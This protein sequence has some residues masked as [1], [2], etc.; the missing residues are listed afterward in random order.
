[1]VV[2]RA[3]SSMT[4]NELVELLGEYGQSNSVESIVRAG[5]YL[6]ALA[7]TFGDRE[8]GSVRAKELHAFHR[9]IC[10]SPAVS[11]LLALLEEKSQ[12]WE[13]A[14]SRRA[15]G[16]VGCLQWESQ[17]PVRALVDLF[18]QKGLRPNRVLELGCGDGVNAV[19][20]ASRGCEVTAVDLS[21][22]ALV[23][24]REKQRAA[25]VDVEFV[26]G[27]IFEL[28]PSREPYD[29]IFDR[30]MFHH[31]QVFQ[32]EDYK[33]LVADRLTPDGYFH[34]ICHHVSARPTV[35][36]DCLCGF[37]GMLLNFVSG[38]LLE[39]G[40]GFTAEELREIF[41][42]RFRFQSMDLIVDDNNRP[43]RFVSSVMQRI[44]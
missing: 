28:E 20:M 13:A 7:H 10:T 44:G 1:M 16:L 42:D 30:G 3:K 36:L 41:S 25:R 35:L 27:D 43:F 23:M 6:E 11:P 19:F 32:F 22:T 31:L 15:E 21:H 40:T 39:M 37:V 5:P 17:Q 8:V 29:F 24:A 34:L 18:E 33:N 12:R 14:Y 38:I 4:M 2:A 9:Q 26:E